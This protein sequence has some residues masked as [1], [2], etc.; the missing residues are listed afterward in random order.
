MVA[1]IAR[2]S[3]IAKIHIAKKEL[4]LVDESYRALLLRVTGFESC[5]DCSESQLDAILKEF[6]RLGYESKKRAMSARAEHAYHRMIFSLWSALKP[7]VQ[8]HSEAA[9][10]SFVKRQTGHDAVQFLG[11]E[12]A[13]DVIEGLKAWLARERD[14]RDGKRNGTPTPK[15]R[16][17]QK[18]KKPR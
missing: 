17:V 1:D 10:R 5:K 2:R 15:V 13:N 4:A 7:F 6:H 9:L 14:K 16:R 3:R 11:P 12:D 8:H 18:R